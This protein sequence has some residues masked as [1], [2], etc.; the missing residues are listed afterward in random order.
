VQE[1]VTYVNAPQIA[2]RLGVTVRETKVG[3]SSNSD[4]VNLVTLRAGSHSIAA[5]LVGQRRQARI[6]LVDDHLT[7]VPPSDHMLVV[8]N[9]DRPGVIGLVGTLLGNHNVNIADMDV[10]RALTPGTALMVIAPTAEVSEAAIAELRA[11]PGIIE[12]SVLKG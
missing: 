8:R 2:Q 12:V 6:V 7:D 10:G 1:Q 4:Y 11:A 9:D 5:T 3:G